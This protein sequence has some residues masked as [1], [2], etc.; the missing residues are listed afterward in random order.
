MCGTSATCKDNTAGE[1]CDAANNVCKCTSTLDSCAGERS[2]EY[3]DALGNSGSGECKCS[4]SVPACSSPTPECNSGTC[5]D[6]NFYDLK[7][8]N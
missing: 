3:C 5:I 7:K 2:G 4:A 8:F 6:G 1:Y